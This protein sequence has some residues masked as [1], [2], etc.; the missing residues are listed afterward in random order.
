MKTGEDQAKPETTPQEAFG[1]FIRG[2]TDAAVN[3]NLLPRKTLAEILR[4]E[5]RIIENSREPFELPH[6][7]VE[8]K[9]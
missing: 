1:A 6:Q 5:A 2:V 7:G 4:N 3:N 8:V 9:A